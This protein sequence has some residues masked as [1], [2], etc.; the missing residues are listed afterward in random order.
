[1]SRRGKL[2]EAGTALTTDQD[3]L[4]ALYCQYAELGRGF[5]SP[6]NVVAAFDWKP[7][8]VERTCRTLE[9]KGW[10][11]R[12]LP[13]VEVM[14][15]RPPPTTPAVAA[16]TTRGLIRI[17]GGLRL[18]PRQALELSKRLREAA[19]ELSDV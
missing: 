15:L 18:T 17:P 14:L 9:N 1:M 12:M 7:E 8:R 16:L 6:W 3:R 13:N 11:K 19:E 4:Y 5:P 10:L 2:K